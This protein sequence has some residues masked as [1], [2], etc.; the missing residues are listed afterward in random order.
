MGA[1]DDS[2]LTR[3]P[4]RSWNTFATPDTAE[5]PSA[6]NGS[7]PTRCR[8]ATN[9]TPPGTVSDY[10]CCPA[11][12]PLTRAELQACFDAADERVETVIESGRKGRLAAFRDAALFKVCCAFACVGGRSRFQRQPGTPEPGGLGVCQVRFCKATH[13]SPPCR[14]RPA[15]RHHDPYRVRTLLPDPGRRAVPPP[16]LRSGGG[17]R[18]RQWVAHRLSRAS[19]TVPNGYCGRPPSRTARIPMPCLA[20]PD[21]QTTAEFLPVLQQQAELTRELLGA[22]ESSGRQWQAANHRTVLINL[23]KIITSLQSLRTERCEDG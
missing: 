3:A 23:D 22:A 5:S 2:P 19:N 16:R 6:S 10:S 7:A 14:L 21:F 11:R 8:S 18:G 1:F 9:G 12:R 4:S 15:A 13:G 20:C 17:D